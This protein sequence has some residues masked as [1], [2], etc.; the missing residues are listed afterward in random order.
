MY[1]PSQRPRA[2]PALLMS[3]VLV[4]GIGSAW[5]VLQAGDAP[6]QATAE[7]T[8]S[9]DTVPSPDRLAEAV[10]KP[11]VA[12]VGALAAS[13]NR[14]TPSRIEA[15]VAPSSLPSAA[16]PAKVAPP[17]VVA[18][19]LPP[20]QGPSA[21]PK[22]PTATARSS[23]PSAAAPAKVASPAVVA[24]KP[25][26]ARAPAAS[27]RAAAAPPPLARKAPIPP[28]APP[29]AEPRSRS[30]PGLP[31]IARGIPVPNFVPPADPPPIIS[32]APPLTPRAAVQAVTAPP[33]VRV[34]IRPQV[35]AATPERAWV[36]LSDQ[37]TVIF[38]RGQAVP[39][40][41]TYNGVIGTVPQF[42]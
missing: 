33:L 18:A 1:K 13:E 4:F 9:L 7:V 3:T 39:G 17:A 14:L 40:L 34:E 41:G 5:V 35:L 30:L 2:L 24:A 29:S 42:D 25:P 26:P 36:K 11:E 27:P 22:A 20:V 10:L 21:P 16:A 31:S 32:P 8:P 6:A 23:P 15:R 28:A 37:Q 38:Q 12:R 19:K